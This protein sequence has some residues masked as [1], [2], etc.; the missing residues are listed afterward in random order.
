MGYERRAETHLCHVGT[1]ANGSLD[2]QT[3]CLQRWLGFNP[4][5]TYE[6]S[7]K[8]PLTRPGRNCGDLKSYRKHLEKQRERDLSRSGVKEKLTEARSWEPWPHS[9][10]CPVSPTD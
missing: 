5:L 7:R 2:G 10:L 8:Y 6:I 3:A 9:R 4:E 1:A